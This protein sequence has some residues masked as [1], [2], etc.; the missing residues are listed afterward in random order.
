LW[1]TNADRAA[2]VCA[3]L[4]HGLLERERG[5]PKVARDWLERGIGAVEELDAS[6]SPA[7]FA[8]DAGVM[9]LGLLATVLVHLG[10]VEQG[11]QRIEA[12][13]V[14]ALALREPAPRVAAFWLE[15]LFE[16]RMGHPGRAA[17]AAERLAQVQ[18]EYDGPEGKAAVLW[19]RGW[20]QAHLGDP[21]AGHRLIREGYERVT[22][23]GMRAYAGETLGY[24]AE[25]LMLAGDWPA[26]RKQIEEARQTAEAAGDRSCLPRLLMLE[27]RV[28]DALGERRRA[29]DSLRE[30]VAE[31]RMQEAAGLELE[32]RSALCERDDATA[33]ELAALRQLV[34]GLS[35]GSDAPPVARARALVSGRATALA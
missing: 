7:V 27:A 33:V 19:F 20:A 24:A 22:R 34:E 28:A 30:A 21:R 10:L 3:C 11:R 12:A 31:A 13:R 9:M 35:E 1:E 26:A 32:A 8:A 17:E 6:T 25:A 29:R 23:C 2:L 15:A 18:E 5:R 16:V 4:V 14:R